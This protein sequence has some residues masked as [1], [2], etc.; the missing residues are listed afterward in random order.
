MLRSL[1]AWF[2]LELKDEKRSDDL[3]ADLKQFDAA[4]NK[5]RRPTVHGLKLAAVE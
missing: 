2:Y 3:I 1:S 5:V 4:A